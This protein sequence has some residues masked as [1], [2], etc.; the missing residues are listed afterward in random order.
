MGPSL[1]TIE[2]GSSWTRGPLPCLPIVGQAY[3]DLLPHTVSI[4]P[5]FEGGGAGSH[6]TLPQ[7]LGI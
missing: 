3:A 5:P 2:G 4:Q 7:P 1:D 6:G